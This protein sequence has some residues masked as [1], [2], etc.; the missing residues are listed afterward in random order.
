MPPPAYMRS[1]SETSFPSASDSRDNSMT[2]TGLREKKLYALIGCLAILTILAI[3]LLI[4]NI[5]LIVS[6]Q[7]NQHGM[8]FLRFHNVFNPKVGEMEKVVQFDGNQVDLGTVVT[9]GNVAGYKDRELYIHGSRVL[10]S[11]AENSTRLIIQESGCR[12]ENTE[13]F[14]VC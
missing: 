4:M 5:M 7:M 6:L 8:K 12:L 1:G 11:G 13:H 3:F 10:M 2:V 9:N 14:Q